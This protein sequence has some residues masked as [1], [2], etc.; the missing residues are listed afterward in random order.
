MQLK[1]DIVKEDCQK[2]LKKLISFFLSN[3]F[4]LMDQVI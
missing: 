1:I 2:A 4:P 3:P